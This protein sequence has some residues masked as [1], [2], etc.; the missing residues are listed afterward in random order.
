MVALPKVRRLLGLEVVERGKVVCF[1]LQTPADWDTL[2][3]AG[4]HPLP[5]YFQFTARCQGRK[6]QSMG[7]SAVQPV[8]ATGQG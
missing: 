8:K 6:S 5:I 3:V 7:R 4:G 2:K 1:S